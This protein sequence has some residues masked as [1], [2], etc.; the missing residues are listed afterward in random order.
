MNIK[1]IIVAVVTI[2]ALWILGP[3]A[4][5][6][7]DAR[8][9]VILDGYEHAVGMCGMASHSDEAIIIGTEG[10]LVTGKGFYLVVNEGHTN[11]KEIVNLKALALVTCN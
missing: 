3:V 2:V 1:V 6:L 10:T 7:S 4:A 9:I 5:R 8:G 11:D